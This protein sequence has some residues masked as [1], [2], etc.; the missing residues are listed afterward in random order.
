MTL[1]W[2]YPCA[3]KKYAEKWE[4]FAEFESFCCWICQQ[5]FHNRKAWCCYYSQEFKNMAIRKAK[6]NMLLDNSVFWSLERLLQLIK[7]RQMRWWWKKEQGV[8]LYMRL[9]IIWE[10]EHE[11]VLWCPLL[12]SKHCHVLRLYKARV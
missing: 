9:S 5:N 2:I 3:T 8:K 6:E 10:C 7:Q 11:Q 1:C 12:T 4:N